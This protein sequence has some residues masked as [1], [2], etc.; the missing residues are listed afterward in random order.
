MLC[1]ADAVMLCLLMLCPPRSHCRF[2]IGLGHVMKKDLLRAVEEANLFPPGWVDDCPSA[3]G[4]DRGSA[5]CQRLS[6]VQVRLLWHCAAPP[7]TDRARRCSSTS[8]RACVS[9]APFL[10]TFVCFLCVSPAHLRARVCLFPAHLCVFPAHP[11]ARGLASRARPPPAN[12]ARLPNFSLRLQVVAMP[13]FSMLHVS[14]MADNLLTPGITGS[15]NHMSGQKG[16]GL[17]PDGEYD[18]PHPPCFDIYKLSRHATMLA[19]I[20]HTWAKKFQMK[21]LRDPT[22]AE[23]AHLDFFKAAVSSAVHIRGV[24][25]SKIEV[26]VK[27]T[28]V[29]TEVVVCL[30]MLKR[31]QRV[32]NKHLEFLL[33]E[34]PDERDGADQDSFRVVQ[35]MSRTFGDIRDTFPLPELCVGIVEDQLREFSKQT[36]LEK[37][38]EGNTTR[39]QLK[40][41]GRLFPYNELDN[42][43]EVLED[44]VIAMMKKVYKALKKDG[45]EPNNNA[46][47]PWVATAYA[48]TGCAVYELPFSDKQQCWLNLVTSLHTAIV[49]RSGRGG[50]L[51]G[52]LTCGGILL[53]GEGED[54]SYTP[55]VDLILEGKFNI[56]EALDCIQSSNVRFVKA[57]IFDDM[58][59]TGAQCAP[60]TTDG[61][62]GVLLVMACLVVVRPPH[63]LDEDLV[64]E[65]RSIA[66]DT[67]VFCMPRSAASKAAQAIRLAGGAGKVDFVAAAKIIKDSAKSCPVKASNL[68]D[69]TKGLFYPNEW[70]QRWL[71]SQ[72][73]KLTNTYDRTLRMY[74]LGVQGIR[75]PTMTDLRHLYAAWDHWRWY[76][77][78]AFLFDDGTSWPYSKFLK[79]KSSTMLCTPDRVEYYI[80]GMHPAFRHTE[81]EIAAQ[82]KE[83][84]GDALMLESAKAAEK[85][86]RARNQK[87]LD[88]AEARKKQR[89]A[90]KD[91]GVVT[92]GDADDDESEGRKRKRDDEE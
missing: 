19:R 55:V 2:N 25:Q 30:D 10:R 88:G 81:K 73:R 7:R 44:E 65:Y 70:Q 12:H 49:Q 51:P 58:G 6:N 39:E 31:L 4:K 14:R 85:L 80:V 89:A 74:H 62:A 56:H 69:V 29:R 23:V 54:M 52:S 20:L 91:R 33:Q 63:D 16:R 61:A 77:G 76:K 46:G 59:K 47:H 42:L 15:G 37:Q 1:P 5:S 92:A 38:N 17:G 27:A 13:V 60:F 34:I 57:E 24:F 40:R 75:S 79:Y 71:A 32:T 41:K 22:Y 28:T 78:Y 86:H 8:A 87:F 72:K 3:V 66:L 18:G 68:N 64:S 35:L 43:D 9:C 36:R 53:R 84:E 82:Q 48:K 45:I 11:G 90:K 83:A 26:G 21:H 67:P 50:D